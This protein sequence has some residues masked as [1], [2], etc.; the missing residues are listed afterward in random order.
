MASRHC[1]L[2]NTSRRGVFNGRFIILSVGKIVNDFFEKVMDA[3]E[4]VMC[5][6]IIAM[7]PHADRNKLL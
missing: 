1:P 7:T 3:Y 5:L 6:K 4:A 2:Q